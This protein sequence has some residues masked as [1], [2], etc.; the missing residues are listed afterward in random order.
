MTG[1]F[2]VT[3]GKSNYLPS[4]HSGVRWRGI[5]RLS[6]GSEEANFSYWRYGHGSTA[7]P[8]RDAPQATFVWGGAGKTR[9]QISC[10]RLKVESGVEDGAVGELVTAEP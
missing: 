5:P 9:I 2:A 3:V 1:L 8:Q 7:E 6:D 10:V 4:D